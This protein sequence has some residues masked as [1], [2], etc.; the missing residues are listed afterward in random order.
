[1]KE[2]LKD[3]QEVDGALNRSL[4]KKT[5]CSLHGLELPFVIKV[6]PWAIIFQFN[7]AAYQGNWKLAY[8]ILSSTNNFPEFTGRICPASL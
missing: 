3:Y 1:M 2:R 8:E 6:A 5:G 4:T 7:D